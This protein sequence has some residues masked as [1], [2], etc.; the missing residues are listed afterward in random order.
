MTDR[1]ASVPF[2]L[3][4]WL[5]A[6]GAAAQVPAGGPFRV[7]T[8][9]TGQQST[10]LVAKT[11]AAASNGD[12]VVV[13]TGPGPAA[14]GGAFA[15]RF[16]AAGAR[17]GAEIDVEGPSPPVAS[18]D[19]SVAFDARGGLIV[20]WGDFSAGDLYLRRFDRE[21]APIAG[22]FVVTTMAYGASIAVDR[23]RGDFVVAWTG[24]AYG[25]SSGIFA[26]RFDASGAPRGLQFL[27]NVHTPSTQ[28][29][30][31][32]A[33]IEPSGDFV[34]AWRSHGQDGDGYGVFARRFDREGAPL[35]SEFRVNSYTPG[36]QASPRIAAAADG[37]FVVA[38]SSQGQDNGFAGI[39]AQ[40]YDAGG[41]PIG[42][43]FRVN[44]YTPSNKIAGDV[45][46][47][48]AG[49]FVVTWTS[50]G[51]DGDNG[52][53]FARRFDSSGAPRG[54]E[55]QVNTFTPLLQELSSAAMDAAGNIVV[56]W[57]DWVLTPNNDLDVYARR[58]GGLQPAALAVDA[59]AG[60]SSNGNRVFEAGESVAVAPTWRNVNGAAQT[61]S[62]T[63]TAFTG[64]GLPG[65]PSY[66]IADGTADYGTV[67]NGAV[68]PCA[69]TGNCYELAISAPSPRPAA[70]WDATLREDISPAAQGQAKL[71]GLH[72]GGTFT[73]VP[74]A[75]PFYRF[76]ETIVHA[77]I[78]GGCGGSGYCPAAGTTREQM[79]VFVL[80]AKEGT[81]Y[82][83]PA[84][85]A[86]PLF[87]DVP[88]TNPFCRW[89]EELA[90]RGV[91]SGCGGGNYCP[92]A[93]VSREQMGVFLSATFGLTLYGP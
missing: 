18:V 8:Y 83:P 57:D 38:W 61:F 69:A 45:A 64:P 13:W 9:T 76:V 55:F 90:R 27:V 3:A 25:D 68:A 79:A 2:V 62:G 15:Q 6:N 7:N 48:E 92:T 67:A 12:F 35:G 30:A 63:A 56:D 71:W 81:S 42:G 47:D 78:T 29:G 43:E 89:I 46:S 73:D 11:I 44:T 86:T 88:A 82:T 16:D 36:G 66:T 53:V 72:V 52:G 49:N 28:A 26:R 10:R 39:Y 34:I 1:R 33:M 37:R 5:A 87:A 58:Y 4:A 51:Q 41:A 40:R 75:N 20:A 22:P 17:L 31:R 32:A 21:G 93:P 19:P 24:A 91:V 14:P 77:G 59:A 70:H 60:P 80:V 23:R 85:G 54:G 84:C 50:N 65:N 74:A